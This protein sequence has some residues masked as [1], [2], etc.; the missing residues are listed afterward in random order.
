MA[1][2]RVLLVAPYPHLEEVAL[3]A[4]EDFPDIDLTI[5]HG[6]LHEGLQAAIQAFGSDFDVVVS[7]GGTAQML[8]DEFSVPVI[9]INVSGA[10]LLRGLAQFNP[11][12]ERCAVVGFSNTL[13]SV[14]Q[15]ADFSDFDLDVFAVDFEDELPLVLQDVLTGGYSVVLCDNFAVSKCAELGIEAHLLESGVASVQDAFSR[16]LF[17]C[18]QVDSLQRKNHVLWDILKSQDADFALFSRSG[19]LMYSSLEEDR[20]E[21]LS[22]MRGHLD[23]PAPAKLTMRRGKKIHRI[24]MIRSGEGKEEVVSFSLTTSNAPS[25]DSLVGIVRVNRDEVEK[26]YRDSVYRATEAGEHSASFLA[27]ATKIEKPIMLEGEVGTG[28]AQIA[29]LLYLNSGLKARPFVVIDCS[30]LTSKS[31]DYLMNSTNSPLYEQG[32]TLYFKAAHALD[33]DRLKF[34]LDVI[35]RTGA[36][37]RNRLIFSANDASGGG[38][39]EQATAIV[40]QLHCVVFTAPPLRERKDIARAA[41]LFV[42]VEAKRTDVEAPIITDEAQAMLERHAWSKNYIELRQVLQRCLAST[43]GTIS[44]QTVREALG[45]EEGTLFSSLATPDAS[46]SI[47]LLRPIKETEREIVQMVVD[48]LGGNQTEAGRILGLSR[49][50]IW[51]MLK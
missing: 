48:K 11:K 6:D 39:T 38:E 10:D 4:V 42:A 9:E 30:L 37:E 13:T 25:G 44:A 15:V 43:T 34:L 23:D 2:Y 28:K 8:E 18:Q 26:S 17:F 36:A 27:N 31:W 12:G 24:T 14:S 22:F 19:R 41:R 21:L 16:T 35:R 1:L 7:R 40:E 45:R 33:D 3:E 49:T 29:A 50:T 47:E 32:D 5:H 51:R 46:T 20:A